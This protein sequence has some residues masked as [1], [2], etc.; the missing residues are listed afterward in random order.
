MGRCLWV[1]ALVSVGACSEANTARLEVASLIDVV[2]EPAG[3]HCATG[4]FALRSGH[5]IDG[6]G[7]LSQNEIQNVEYRCQSEDGLRVVIRERAEPPG[8]RCERGGTIVES[9]LD[10]NVNGRLDDEEV[11]ESTYVCDPLDPPAKLLSRVEKLAAGATCADGGTAIYS[12][13]DVDGDGAL[14]ASEVERTDVV[15]DEATT[16]PEVE[17]VTG[18]GF[19][20]A[21]KTNGRVWCWGSNWG[22]Q[23]GIPG[24]GDVVGAVPVVGAVDATA[25]VAGYA[26]ACALD[27][28]GAA[29]CWGSNSSGQL[30]HGDT[31]LA[32]MVPD[33]PAFI[34]LAAGSSHTCGLTKSGEVWCWGS[35][36][37][38][39]L[40]REGFS[41]YRQ[42]AA[43]EGISDAAEIAAGDGYTCALGHDGSVWC[44]G[45]QL[46]GALDDETCNFY[47]CHARPT[48]VERLPSAIALAPGAANMCVLTDER[49]AWC[50]GSNQ[51][52]Q[53]GDGT[54]K[55]RPTPAPVTML[56]D[57]D[58][59]A[60]GSDFACAIRGDGSLW[61]WGNNFYG[62]LAQGAT[63][64][65]SLVPKVVPG[66]L[67]LSGLSLGTHHG[68]GLRDGAP[69]C[70][71]YNEGGQVGARGVMHPVEV[72]IDAHSMS[73][74][75]KAGCAVVRDGGVWCWGAFIYND[76][77]GIWD[78]LPTRK[79][80]LPPAASVAVGDDHACVLGLDGSVWCW[81]G[82]YRHQLG[83]AY[84]SS[85][86]T[87][88]RVA[89][90]PDAVAIYA[91]GQQSCA[92]RADG[93]L[94]CWGA[95]GQYGASDPHQTLPTVTHVALGGYHG[96]AVDAEA[97]AW[98]W[99]WNDY[100]QVSSSGMSTMPVTQVASDV[101]LVAASYNTTCAVRIDGVTMCWGDGSATPKGAG[102]GDVASIEFGYWHRCVVRPDATAACMGSNSHGQ[103][104]DGTFNYRL[105]LVPVVGLDDIAD[106]SGGYQQTC[107]LRRD[108]S[109]WCWGSN[110]SGQIGNGGPARFV[111]SPSVVEL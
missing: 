97:R 80:G 89:A 77:S 30:G 66:M 26:H 36:Y 82:N 20:C 111:V 72:L 100:Q 63:G 35:N 5:D 103:I 29:W 48:L 93:S 90:I 3:P 25:L 67:G 91:G 1:L 44:W 16:S 39:E 78:L 46:G 76:W 81:G 49:D 71:G 73:A 45:L 68:C 55:K 7:V 11:T 70:W 12:G 61:C 14:A 109:V 102:F 8:A 10:A 74:G 23:L 15:C 24:Y 58:E 92:Q 18:N 104:G 52:G 47:P 65:Y 101:A 38:G 85:T 32:R 87:P 62:Q 110:S 105:T 22:Y 9:G 95:E 21:R 53:L 59:L 33:V 79:A 86:M 64:S 96:C 13:R 19:S 43:V 83:A 31:Y 99:G 37:Y 108:G 106:V 6:D 69:Y 42:P 27:G 4:G 57:V 17:V 40:G 84:P 28:H 75:N 98:C 41:S 50:W 56:G 107:A 34:A 51:D 54:S 2:P 60:G 94:W 88:V